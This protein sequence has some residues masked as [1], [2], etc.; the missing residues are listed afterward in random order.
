MKLYGLIGFP[1]GH[2]FS[3]KYFNEK[4]EQEGLGDC[5]FELFPIESIDEFP[6][7]LRN[8]PELK[9]LA[10][11]IPYKKSVIPFLDELNDAAERIG[12]VNCI[13]F[14][15]G[16]LKGYNTDVTG[17][18]RSFVPLLQPHHNK[19]L[20]LGTGGS[21][22]AVKY[23]LDQL[24][25]PFKV[26]SRSPGAEELSYYDIDESLLAEYTVI[27]NCT[28]VGMTPDTDAAPDLPYKFIHSKHYC[29]D[30]IYTPAETKFLR[31]AKA[32]G[33]T[34]MNGYDMLL[35]QAEENWR[36][37]QSQGLKV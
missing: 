25:I 24:H 6:A 13:K 30:L 23:T 26:V 31:L 37:W 2:S 8:Q 15:N 9:G 3:K 18:E 10:V 11:T 32:N 1:L 16:K 14:S 33:A 29:Y 36:V 5:F 34:I 21:S 17:F 19:A 12:A 27:I 7:L 35:I 28:P 20:V 22:N 4:F